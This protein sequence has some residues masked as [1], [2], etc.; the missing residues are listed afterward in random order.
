M[1]GIVVNDAIILLHRFQYA[2]KTQTVVNA[3]V[4]ACCE[5]FRAVTLTTVTTV[6]GMLPLLL[7]KSLQAQFVIPLAVSV[8]AGL[9]M[10]TTMLIILLPAVTAL[11]EQFCQ[12]PKM[13]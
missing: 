12:A 6:L 1:T 9:M 3:M 13:D 8:S 10:A 7:N 4:T 2:L 11:V 5:R